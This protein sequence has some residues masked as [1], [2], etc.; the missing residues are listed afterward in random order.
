[1]AN[2]EE[3]LGI[4]RVGVV[5]LGLLGRGITACLLAGDLNVFI[6]DRNQEMQSEL[7]SYLE[8]VMS[9]IAEHRPK[10]A[11]TCKAWRAHLCWASELKELKQC[12][13]VIESIS[14]SL[15]IK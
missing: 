10:V 15:P 12:D 4:H 1:M 14:E 7:L 13:L 5:G 8:A 6:F 9:E 3:R 2:N 11:A